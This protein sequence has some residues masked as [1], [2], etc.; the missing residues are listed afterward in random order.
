MK[1]I[2]Y[3]L[4][5]LLLASIMYSCTKK[6]DGS[7]QE[8][9]KTSIDEIKS[10]LEG[11]KKDQF[12]QSI[13]L[14]LWD[15]LDFGGIP[16]EIEVNPMS[17]PY[18]KNL[19]G[20]TSE[21]VITKGRKIAKKEVDSLYE[22]KNK[23]EMHK[24]KLKQFK[25]LEADIYSREDHLGREENIIQLKVKNNSEKPISRIYFNGILKSPERSVP[26]HEE[27]FN[28]TISGG[29]EPGET[30]K[31]NLSPSMMSDWYDVEI[32]DDAKFSVEVTRV[33]DKNEELLYSSD[34]LDKDDEKMLNELVEIYPQ[35]EKKLPPVNHD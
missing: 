31:W 5:I 1:K 11:K 12:V 27:T 20:M 2:I 14:I 10:D 21:E 4:S 30:K 18:L 26:Y 15:N 17:Y 23:A 9:L 32:P 3:I 8:K 25:I 34:I 35:I 24:E 29:L 6:I 22:K 28:H 13:G 16:G 33:N 19:D 7:S